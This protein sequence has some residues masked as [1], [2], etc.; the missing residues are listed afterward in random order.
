VRVRHDLGSSTVHDVAEYEYNGLHWRT[1]RRED[2]NADGTLDQKRVGTYSSS[3]QLVHEDVDDAY[4]TSAGTDKRVQ[5]FWGLRYIDDILMHRAYVTPSLGP[6]Q[7]EDPPEEDED[8]DDATQVLDDMN[9]SYCKSLINARDRGKVCQDEFEK[10]WTNHHCGDLGFSVAS[11]V[12]AAWRA[13]LEESLLEQLS[14]PHVLLDAAGQ[15]PGLGEVAD[16]V[17]GLLYVM[18][19]NWVEAGVSAAAMVPILGNAVAVRRSLVR[20]ADAVHSTE[21]VARRAA[22]Q[23]SGIGRGAKLTAT[24]EELRPGSRSPHGAPG[25]RVV[26]TDPET[27]RSFSLD[28]FGHRYNGG[29]DGPHYNDMY[30]NHH[31]FPS[32]HNPMTNR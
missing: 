29:F 9:R 7:G 15:I 30:G 18:E 24:L 6:P 14:D 32:P 27:G 20:A 5:Y 10:Q 21:R 1:V 13:G 12:N 25:H 8:T 19:G 3:W 4:A 22:Q 16:G 2:T 23:A 28:P 17:N 31:Y 11:E 26:L